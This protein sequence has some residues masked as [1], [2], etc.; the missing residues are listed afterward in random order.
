MYDSTAGHVGM[1]WSAYATALHLGNLGIRVKTITVVF[2][3]CNSQSWFFPQSS[4]HTSYV[5]ECSRP[6]MSLPKCHPNDTFFICPSRC[7]NE[8]SNTEQP[9]RWRFRL[10][11]RHASSRKSVLRFPSRA[12]GLRSYSRGC[13]FQC[14]LGQNKFLRG[15]RRSTLYSRRWK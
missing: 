1:S 15:K 4:Y 11:G 12:L 10:S 8:P 2:Y 5:C 6:I 13:L 9:A 7:R 3:A 14:I